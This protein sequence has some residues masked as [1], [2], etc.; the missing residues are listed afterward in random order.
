MVAIY[1]D[2]IIIAGKNMNQIS[3]F[4]KKIS[5]D[6]INNTYMNSILF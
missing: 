6:L 3:E 2:D 4:K 5:V 1:V